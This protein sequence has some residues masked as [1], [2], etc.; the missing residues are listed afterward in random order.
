[1]KPLLL[2]E[3]MMVYQIE[4]PFVKSD[5]YKRYNIETYPVPHNESGLTVKIQAINDIAVH[6][7]QGYCFTPRNCFVWYPEPCQIGPLFPDST[8][9]S[10]MKQDDPNTSH[11]YWRRTVCF[12]HTP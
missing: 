6:T 5:V 7:T 10:R 3:G 8:F 12:D 9:E 1:M 2:E 4:L 11:R